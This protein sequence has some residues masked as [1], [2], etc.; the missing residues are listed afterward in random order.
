[1]TVAAEPA[2]PSPKPRAVVADDSPEQRWL[3]HEILER[4]GFQISEAAD[5]RGLFWA[6]ER[7]Q[8]SDSL[9]SLVVIADVNMPIYGGL[10]V[11]EAWKHEDWPHAFVVMTGFPDDAVERRARD[12]GA[13]LLSKPFTSGDLSRVVRRLTH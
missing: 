2:Q 8:R 3:V 1:M 6:L 7:C 4:L 13:V 12:L 10:D 11:L 9:D 5:G